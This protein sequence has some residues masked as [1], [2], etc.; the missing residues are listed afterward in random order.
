M[1][2]KTLENSRRKGSGAG[3]SRNNTGKRDGHKPNRRRK[4]QQRNQTPK[5][6][7]KIETAHFSSN[8]HAEICRAAKYKVH[9]P[10]CSCSKADRLRQRYHQ[11]KDKFDNRNISERLKDLDISDPFDNLL[12]VPD[13]KTTPAIFVCNQT[14]SIDFGNDATACENTLAKEIFDNTDTTSFDKF[15]FKVSCALCLLDHQKNGFVAIVAASADGLDP[16]IEKANAC[17]VANKTASLKLHSD[18]AHFICAVQLSS[19][20]TL[21]RSAKTRSKQNQI[22]AE[23]LSQL[24]NGDVDLSAIDEE[25]LCSI[26]LG[27][28]LT[29]LLWLEGTLKGNRSGQHI[30]VLGYIDGSTELTLDLPGGKRHLGESTLE[31]LVRE[32][33]EESSLKLDKQWLAERLSRRYGGLLDRNCEGIHA[34]ESTKENGNVY[35]I[36][37]PII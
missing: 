30:M 31:S 33:E 3:G 11:E 35:F 18:H 21:V 27:H 34:L 37:P 19:L 7:L 26:K 10:L 29:S 16:T 24:K 8:F 13:T 5:H 9:A 12:V 36:V 20:K 14:T 6:L 4:A 17:K 23:I 28:H 22:V 1:A 32:V 25:P 15:P 2:E